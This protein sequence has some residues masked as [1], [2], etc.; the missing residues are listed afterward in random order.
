MIRMNNGGIMRNLMGATSHDTHTRKIWGTKAAFDF[1]EGVSN[2]FLGANGRCAGYEVKPEWPE[3]GELADTA[4]HGG[5]DFWELLYFA[6]EI[7][8][9]EKAPWDIYSACDVCLAGIMSVRSYEQGGIPMEVPDF[10]DPAVREKYRNDD[11]I[12]Q[13]FDPKT[14]LFPEGH[15]TEISGKFSR[16]ITELFQAWKNVG[17]NVVRRVFDGMKVYPYLASDS[18]KMAVIR[19]IKELIN[20]IDSLA[21]TYRTAKEIIAAYPDSKAAEALCGLLA[22]GEEEKILNPEQTKK[23]LTDWLTKNV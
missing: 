21:E 3:Y 10:R 15:N 11:F 1:S 12:Q 14:Y 16:T 13:H 22:I 4:G 7:L 18:S 2:I 19:D 5:G 20:S 23:E 6:R 8:T 17:V 9:G